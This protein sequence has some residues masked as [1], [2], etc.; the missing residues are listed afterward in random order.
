MD[1]RIAALLEAMKKLEQELLLEIEKKEAEFYY[2]VIGK[3]VRF[4][5][6]I[7]RQ[8]RA[9]VFRL[10]QYLSEASLFNLLTAP[11]IWFMLIPALF[12]DLSVTAFQAACFRVYGIPRV[13]RR[14]YIV[15]DHQALA[16]LNLIEKL[17]CLYC[18]YFNGL[19]AYAQEVAARTEQYW[20]PIKHARRLAAMHSRYGKFLEYGDA[21]GYRKHLEEVRRAF[22]DLEKEEAT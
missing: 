16:Y 8:H 13:K 2:T 5:K 21:D 19:I 17:N 3:K 15:I 1:T 12:L 6:E 9:L 11:L 20:C 7:R 22:A 4:E 10:S 14:R 18:S